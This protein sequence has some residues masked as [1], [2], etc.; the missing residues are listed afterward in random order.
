MP[1]SWAIRVMERG[2]ILPFGGL[3]PKLVLLSLVLPSL[4]AVSPARAGDEPA[5]QGDGPVLPYLRALHAKVHR[6]WADNFVA[7]AAAQLPKDH[8][9]NAASRAVD[10]EV[11]ISPEGQLADVKVA[12]TSGAAD[13]DAA[14][15]EVIKAAA[16]FAVAPEDALSDDGNA[17]VLWTLARDDRRC[18]GLAILYNIRALDVA[19]PALVAQ[20]RDLAAIARLQSS[21]EKDRE[22]AF[23]TFARAWLDLAEDDKDLDVRVAAA[24]ASAG[25]GRGAERLRRAVENGQDLE[26]AARALAALRIPLCT[27]VKDKLGSADARDAVLS[28]LRFGPDGECLSWMVNLAKDQKAAQAQR[29]VAI[30]ALGNNDEVEARGVIRNLLG[31]RAPAIQAA[32]ILAGA[33]AGAGKGAMLRLTPLLRNRSVEIRAA[34]AAA[35]VRVGGEP[36]L[37]H[38]FLLFKETDPRPYEAVAEQLAWLT[39][40]ASADM[41]G[42]FLRREDRRIR[43]AGALALARRRDPFAA[44]A[45]AALAGSPDPELRFLA[46]NAV[47]SDKRLAAASAPEGYAWTEDFATL[48]EGSGGIAAVDWMLAQFPKLSPAIRV[49]LMGSWLAST[50]AAK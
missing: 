43:R 24:N 40:Q 49:D 48:A 21:D 37:V 26:L 15:M 36:A 12:N 13:F 14:A 3:M 19:V 50:R 4:F 28:V 44:K 20:G 38:L 30:A 16:P 17:H 25:D 10:L 33:R 8:P 47:D 45:Q 41:L 32:A 9:I 5:V 23:S 11:V 29:L 1:N 39:G 35:L 42:R 31:D 18:S 46:G 34:A 22:R 27:L 6:D 2:P 7:M